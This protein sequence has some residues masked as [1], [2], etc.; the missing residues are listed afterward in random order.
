MVPPRTAPVVWINGFP[1]SGKLTVAT[2]VAALDKTVIVLDNHK[3][4]DPVEARFARIHPSYQH[5][6]S[7]FRQAILDRY[8]YDVATLS[9]LVI[10]TDFQSNNA[11]GRVVA[12][13]YKDAAFKAGRPFVPVYLTCD[14]ATN[15]ER[16]AS[17]DRLGSGTNKLTDPQVLGDLRSR[18]ELYQFDGGC[19]GLTVDSTSLIPSEV[20]AKIVEFAWNSASS[21][22]DGADGPGWERARSGL[23]I[24]IVA[25]CSLLNEK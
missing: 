23:D 16:V 7:L 24:P 2:A 3:L 21:L 8:V 25:D 6:R 11:L 10:F 17:P 15:L 4:I 14:E 1:G 9:R 22:A 5:E 12:S 18:C 20:A 13:E 19:L